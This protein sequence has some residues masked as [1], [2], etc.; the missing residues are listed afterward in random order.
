M[1]SIINKFRYSENPLNSMEEKWINLL[2]IKKHE[3]KTKTMN[4]NMVEVPPIE[5]V[6][7]NL[8]EVE[9][10]SIESDCRFFALLIGCLQEHYNNNI[11]EKSMFIMHYKCPV[12]ELSIPEN[13]LYITL[14]SDIFVMDKNK[15]NPTILSSCLDAD[16]GQWVVKLDNKDNTA[17]TE[18]EN[19]Y[20]GLVGEGPL[21]Q[22]LDKWCERYRE[23]MLKILS[24]KPKH[25]FRELID[26]KTI[27]KNILDTMIKIN[28][29]KLGIY[30]Y[31]SIGE[32]ENINYYECV[33]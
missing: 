27:T 7:N 6:I 8:K 30:K 22:S 11:N 14:D 25:N 28:G 9:K 16:Q 32:P 12:I 24:D 19:N 31:N 21:I 2:G 1:D 33:D 4:S 29:L 15:E 20:L 26:I 23:N 13:C 3:I 10:Y 17:K 5:S 18:P